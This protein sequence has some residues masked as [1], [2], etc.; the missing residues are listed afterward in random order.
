MRD[1]R[2]R[3]GAG[4]RRLGR[5]L[6]A[7]AVHLVELLRLRVVRL[8]APRSR[9]ARRARCPRGGGS[10]RS[11]RRGAGRAPP[12]RASSRRRRSSAP[13]A[14]TAFPVLV[15][16]G[17]RGD[18]A[19]LDEHVLGE[20]V[21]RLARQP[22]APLEQEDPLA[23]ARQRAGE[24]AAAGARPDDDH[25]EV[26]HGFLLRRARGRARCRGPARAA[27]P[28]RGPSCPARRGAQAA[29]CRGAAGRC[30]RPPR[31]RPGG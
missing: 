21:L 31:P 11:P 6:A 23:G 1:G 25:V 29:A 16:P 3:V 8:E 5:V 26:V 15:V 27:R 14:G 7:G 24:R 30:A 17:V 9:W 20:P 19:V 12:R 22:V 2:E 28:P 18:V 4:G 13:A 10:R